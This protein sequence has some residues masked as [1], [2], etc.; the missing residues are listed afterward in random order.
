MALMIAGAS[1]VWWLG[2]HVAVVLL[3]AID[4]NLPVHRREGANAQKSAWLWTAVLVLA[5]L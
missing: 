1:W 3:L 5:I 2:F 4:A